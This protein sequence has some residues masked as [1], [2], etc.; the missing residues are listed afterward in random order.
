V[1][2]KNVLCNRIENIPYL[3]EHFG[4]IP[5]S[6]FRKMIESLNTV[7]SASYDCLRYLEGFSYSTRGA[8]RVMV[9]D[10]PSRVEHTGIPGTSELGLNAHQENWIVINRTLDYEEEYNKDFSLSLLVASASNPKGSRHVRNQFD[11]SKKMAEDRRKKLIKE[12]FIDTHKWAP[13]GWAASVDTAEEL[14]AELERQM[15]GV[16]DRHD[17]FMEKY[18]EKIREKAAKKAQEAEERLKQL[19]EGREDFFI[20]GSQHI[21]TPE[22]TKKLMRKSKSN[23]EL[24]PEQIITPEDKDKFYKKIGARVLTGK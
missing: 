4:R 21:L 19:R 8:W 17:I 10:L 6:L 16:K 23:V 9:N 24:V 13:E 11:S 14:V 3:Y 20:D 7:R 18:M 15:T 1:D 22:E 2:N 5:E 12:G